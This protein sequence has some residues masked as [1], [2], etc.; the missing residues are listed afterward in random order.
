[1]KMDIVSAYNFN[2]SFF[3]DAFFFLNK[4]FGIETNNL[5]TIFNFAF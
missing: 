4:A 2:N 1:M 3:N 5:F